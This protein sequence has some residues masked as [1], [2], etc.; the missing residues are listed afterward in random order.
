MDRLLSAR[1][2]EKVLGIPAATVRSWFRRRKATGL[3]D[4][5]RDQR[6]HP[7]F[8]ERDLLALRD[9]VKP[10]VDHRPLGV[11]R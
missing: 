2:A 10:R 11:Q 4:F 3:Y 9:R 8:R 7:M 6:N 5:G 1:D